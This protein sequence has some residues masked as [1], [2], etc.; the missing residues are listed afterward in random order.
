MWCV[1]TSSIK[2][3][4]IVALLLG[5]CV[6][7]RTA[8]LKIKWVSLVVF[9]N[10]RTHTHV[11]FFI[12]ICVPTSIYV[13]TRGPSLSEHVI[14]MMLV[15]LHTRIHHHILVN[16]YKF[17]KIDYTNGVGYYYAY[18]YTNDTH[19]YDKNMGESLFCARLYFL[20]RFKI[21]LYFF[22]LHRRNFNLNNTKSTYIWFVGFNLAETP[23]D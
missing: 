9:R 16:M 19:T 22:L 10:T 20:I 23:F 13:R 4:I 15:K 17:R 5:W 11:V 3:R 14:M 7:D 21:E 12:Y 18:L 1:S 8:I 6:V 2:M